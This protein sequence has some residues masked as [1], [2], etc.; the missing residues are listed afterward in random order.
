M[1]KPNNIRQGATFDF[2]TGV[3]G[4]DESGFTTTMDVM[5]YPGDTPAISRALSYTNGSFKGNLTSAETAALA[6]GQWFIHI[7]SADSDE[8]LR[9]PIKRYISK[10][11]M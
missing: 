11:W 4:D 10:G 2:D 3:S 9:E 6:V 8:D 5:Q 7:T 1:S